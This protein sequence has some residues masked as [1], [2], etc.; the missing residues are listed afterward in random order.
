MGKAWRWDK[1]SFKRTVIDTVL[2]KVIRDL[3]ADAGHERPQKQ[4][5][6]LGGAGTSKKAH[7]QNFFLEAIEPRLLLSADINYVYSVGDAVTKFTDSDPLNNHYSLS[8][9]GNTTTTDDALVLKAENG[10]VIDSQALSTGG[11]NKVSITG[12]ALLGDQLTIDL[13]AVPNQDLAKYDLQVTMDGKGVVPL[14]PQFDK[15]T[16]TGDGGYHLNSFSL[17]SHE[18]VTVTGGIHADTGDVTITSTSTSDGGVL[19]TGLLANAAASITVN[20]GA[21]ISGANVKLESLSTVNVDN[22]GFGPSFAKLTFITSDSSADVTVNSGSTITAMGNLTIHAESNVTTNATTAPSS[23][24]GSDSTDAAVASSIVKSAA[25]VLIGG[26]LS[27]TGNANISSDNFV[28]VTSTADGASGGSDGSGG[29]GAGATVGVSVLWGNTTVGMTGGSLS[30]DNVTLAATSDRHATTLSNASQ[31][32]AESG[33]GNESQNRLANPNPNTANDGKSVDAAQTS[34]GSLPFAAAVAV[35]VVTGDTTA[36]IS[37][38]TVTST[39]DIDLNASATHTVMTTADG[40]TTADDKSGSLAVGVGAAIGVVDADSVA[41]VGGSAILNAGNVILTALMPASTYDTEATSGAS[42]S[43]SG[44]SVA[45]SLAINVTKISDEALVDSGAPNVNGANLALTATSTSTSTAKA[46]AKQSGG[47]SVGVGASFALNVVNDT[48]MAGLA[49]GADL[50]NAHNLTLL[51]TTVD[52]TVT[53]AQTGAAGGIAIS[54]S[55]AITIENVTTQ[56]S[57]GTGSLLTLTGTLSATAAQTVSVTNTA[58]GDAAGSGTAAIGLSLALTVATDTVE[59]ATSRSITAAGDITFDAHGQA[60]N[61]TQASASAKGGKDTS[62]DGGSG[63]KVDDKSQAQ[64]NAG[65]TAAA[66]DGG[67]RFRPEAPHPPPPPVTRT[68]AAAPRSA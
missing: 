25:S 55:V 61:D 64:L 15:V 57:I 10:N 51:A 20:S 7:R 43:G 9:V 33:S 18:G 45:G 36:S 67:E 14:T 68:A 22:N 12:S 11:V 3:F 6:R 42:G 19:G 16:V 30:A 2:D 13:S 31:G 44:I 29:G 21:Q 5:R 40:S 62:S 48:T 47:G 46:M 37:G 65:N 27:A 60:P 28:H 52:T 26:T 41:S 1:Q 59:A 24:G 49:D 4:K 50:T 23:S 8:I 58:L 32:G 56:A 34:D 66:D 53:E 17:S 38:G 63:N 39:H 54:P 35:G